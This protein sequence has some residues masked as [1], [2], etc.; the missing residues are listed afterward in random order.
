MIDAD[1]RREA[2]ETLLRCRMPEVEIAWVVAARD[3]ATVHMI[4]ELHRERLEEE[5]EERR[6]L[7]GVVEAQLSRRATTG[8]RQ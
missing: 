1:V 3:P 5:L 8:V 7:L 4:V 6:R 2:A